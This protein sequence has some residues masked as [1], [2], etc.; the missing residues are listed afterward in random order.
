MIQLTGDPDNWSHTVLIF[1]NIKIIY[2]DNIRDTGST[3]EIVKF[4]NVTEEK[5]KLVMK[6]GIK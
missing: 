2:C 3:L 6:E 1:F 4:Y 5:V